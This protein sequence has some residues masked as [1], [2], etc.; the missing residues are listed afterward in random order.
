MRMTANRAMSLISAWH[1]HRKKGKQVAKLSWISNNSYLRFVIR[2]KSIMRTVRKNDE[3]SFA[4]LIPRGTPKSDLL[5]KSFWTSRC[6]KMI[7]REKW[8]EFH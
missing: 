1:F 6:G 2:M 3:I 4:Y 8:L 5:S 7:L